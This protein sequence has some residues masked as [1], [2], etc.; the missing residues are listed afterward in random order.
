VSRYLPSPEEVKDQQTKKGGWTRNVL[1]RWGVHWP[2]ENGWKEKLEQLWKEQESGAVVLECIGCRE[3]K[4]F[5]DFDPYPIC[6]DCQTWEE[7]KFKREHEE[8]F[9]IRRNERDVVHNGRPEGVIARIANAMRPKYKKAP[10]PADIRW[11]VWERDNYT[12]QHCGSRRN[13]TVDHV[14]PEVKGGEMTMDN[15]QTLCKSCN[16]R[17]GPR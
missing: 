13:L 15:A 2:P 9:Y 16:S 6:G 12:C 1:T 10:I 4:V 7:E 3:L 14:F 8:T 11:A 17:K 5:A